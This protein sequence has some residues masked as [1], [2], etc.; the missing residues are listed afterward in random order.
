[1]QKYGSLF[2]RED[3]AGDKDVEIIRCGQ[4]VKPRNLVRYSRRDHRVKNKKDVMG[5]E[6]R[7]TLK[8]RALKSI[9]KR[10]Q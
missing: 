9:M 3:Q 6:G 2:R 1:M 8:I 5:G 10:S 7:V 4:E